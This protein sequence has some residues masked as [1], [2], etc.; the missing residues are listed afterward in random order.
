MTEKKDWRLRNQI[1]YLFGVKLTLINYKPKNENWEHDH[2]EFCWEKFE[3]E[4]QK[5]YATKDQY[6]WVCTECYTD[7]K[8][9]FNWN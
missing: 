1:D 6:H 9:M 8:E 7:F 4:N 3:D 2:C 5:G